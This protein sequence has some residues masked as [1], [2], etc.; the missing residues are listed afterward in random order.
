MPNTLSL[1]RSPESRQLLTN[2]TVCI[3]FVETER[4]GGLFERLAAFLAPSFRAGLAEAVPDFTISFERY[5]AFP[6]LTAEASAGRPLERRTIRTSSANMF[7]LVVD[8]VSENARATAVH[9]NEKWTAFIADRKRRNITAYVTEASFIH[10]VELVRYTAL[11]L[12]EARGSILLHASAA[13]ADGEAVLVLGHKGAGKTTTL[14]RMLFGQQLDYMS[15]DKVLLGS[16]A[17][18]L[19]LRSWPDYPHVGIGTLR[20]HA[21]FAAK[22]GVA[23]RWPGGAAKP[24]SHKELIDPGQFRAA[25]PGQV[26][27]SCRRVRALLFP[28]IGHKGAEG[29]GEIRPILARERR[30]KTLL[31]H[32]EFA[33]EFTPGKWHGLCDAVART[34]RQIDEALLERLC[35]VPWYSVLGPVAAPLPGLVPDPVSGP[36]SGQRA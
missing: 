20:A 35:D 29:G 15:G 6:G 7:N 10:L 1:E 33:H 23:L 28:R 16:D 3:C 26:R 36:L 8:V 25:L 31:E 21:E 2:G 13:V 27:Y 22:C 17:E 24:D 12:E 14:L 19:I 18:G 34:E 11:L 5:E 4:S 32:V 30:L 9:D